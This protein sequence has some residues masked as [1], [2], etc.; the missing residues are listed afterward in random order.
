MRSDRPENWACSAG[1]QFRTGS[2]E[3]ARQA[4]CSHF[5]AGESSSPTAATSTPDVGRSNRDLTLS[6]SKTVKLLAGAQAEEKREE[7]EEMISEQ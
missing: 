3:S 6:Y 1:S 2:S 4:A 5:A 7:R